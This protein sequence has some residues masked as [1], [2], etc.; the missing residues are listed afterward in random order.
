MKDFTPEHLGFTIAVLVSTL[1][2]VFYHFY[3]ERQRD[4]FAKGS[5]KQV[6]IQRLSG[7]F[8]FGFLP[9]LLLIIVKSGGEI[10]S[11]IG[12]ASSNILIPLGILTALLIPVSFYNAKG[13]ENLSM[14]PQIREENWNF[15]LLVVSALSW[16]AYLFAYEFLFRGIFLSSSLNFL[17]LWPAIILNVGIYSLVHIPKG[18][19]EAFWS[20]VLGVIMCLL[21]IQTGSFWIAFFIHVVLALSNEWFSLRAHPDIHFKLN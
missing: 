17:G 14:Y 15:S 9:A 3:N 4:R 18:I 5:L 7:V 12:K 6:L 20:I 1:G 10:S 21:V 8:I 11:F 19:K 13:E 2:F 16:I